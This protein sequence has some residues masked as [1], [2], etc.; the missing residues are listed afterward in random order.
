[1]NNVTQEAIEKMKGDAKQLTQNMKIQAP[2]IYDVMI[3]K[4]DE[5][6]ARALSSAEE[7][8]IVAVVGLAHCEGIISTL[9]NEGNYERVVC[10][11]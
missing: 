6:M 10:V 7:S 11:P 2:E 9:V 1:M 3:R 4:R 8:E 5:Y